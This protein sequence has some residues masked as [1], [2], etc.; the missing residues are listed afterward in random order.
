VSESENA[1][2]APVLLYDGVCGVC[3]RG[4]RAILRFDRRN[5]L[6]FAALDSDFARGV[7]ARHPE[8]RDVDS[9]V[10]VRNPG[11]S[12]ETVDVQSAAMFRV[13]DYLGG[14]WRLAQTARVIP[15]PLRDWA[16]ARFAT[17]RYHVGGRY[18]TCPIPPPEVRSRF[19]DA[20]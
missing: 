18:E 12:D 15:P 20:A 14:A 2:T 16:Y 4:V 8:L 3:N 5:T 10:Y 7:V 9:V 1:S 17:I 11:R 13:A 19:I 6:R